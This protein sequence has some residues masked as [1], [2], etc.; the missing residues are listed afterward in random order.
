MNHDASYLDLHLVAGVVNNL[1]K[2]NERFSVP[3]TAGEF[4]VIK[5]ACSV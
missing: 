4:M 1:L 2:T 5:Q 3:V